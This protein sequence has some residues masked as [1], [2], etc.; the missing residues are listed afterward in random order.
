MK[1][2]CLASIFAGLLI[3]ADPPIDTV[4]EEIEKLQGTWQIITADEGA[5]PDGSLKD[6]QVT[7]SGNQFTT[8]SGEKILRQGTIMIDPTCEPKTIDLMYVDG[9]YKGKS[10][11]GIYNL[12]GNSWVL[13]FSPPGKSRPAS[14]QRGA[15][16]Q[17]FLVLKSGKG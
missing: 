14:L 16:N 13:V 2:Q 10:S 5:K 11:L 7:I 9:P 8:K 1:F 3:G 12:N 6:A 15:S 4:Q 17:K